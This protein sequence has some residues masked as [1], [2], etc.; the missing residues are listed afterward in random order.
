[1][2]QAKLF[3]AIADKLRQDTGVGGLVELT[4]HT[5]SD[6]RIARGNILTE[7]KNPF[8]SIGIEASSPV[9]SEGGAQTQRAVI[10]FSAY[11]AKDIDCLR[12][13]DRMEELLLFYGRNNREYYDF[14]ND[15][16]CNQSTK[17]QKRMRRVYDEDCD[18]WMCSVLASI[19]WVIKS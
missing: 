4:G 1:M 7:R 10:K 16:I 9:I 18:T 14:S 3:G 15:E 6:I 12:L 8:L 13:A 11:A 2:S 5:A 19:T 17:F